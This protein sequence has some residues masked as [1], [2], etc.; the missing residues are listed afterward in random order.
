[1]LIRFNEAAKLRLLLFLKKG[2]EA[3]RGILLLKRVGLDLRA[4]NGRYMINP[5]CGIHIHDLP[6]ADDHR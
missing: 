3:K 4:G 5:V 1:M 6:A 2:M